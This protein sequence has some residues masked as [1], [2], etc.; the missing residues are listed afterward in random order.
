MQRDMTRAQRD[1]KMPKT[2]AEATQRGLSIQRKEKCRE[3]A[4]LSLN[5]LLFCV[6]L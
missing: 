4:K 5:P 6:L 1:T 2:D 3:V